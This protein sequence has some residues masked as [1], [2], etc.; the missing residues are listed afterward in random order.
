MHRIREVRMREGI[1][2][3]CASKRMGVTARVA[4]LQERAGTDLR[5][6]DLQRWQAALSVPLAELLVDDCEISQFA[7]SRSKLVLVMKT[8]QAIREISLDNSRVA[9]LVDTMIGQLCRVMPELKGVIAWNVTG[10]RTGVELGRVEGNIFQS[11]ID[12]QDDDDI[13]WNHADHQ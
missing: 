12:L 10:P 3:R 11:E 13:A 4:R 2:I 9:R 7:L 6:S 5:L 8:A 1:S